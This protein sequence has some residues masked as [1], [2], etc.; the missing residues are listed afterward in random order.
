MKKIETESFYLSCNEM[1]SF[2]SLSLENNENLMCRHND[3]V[4]L[5]EI[6]VNDNTA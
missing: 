4:L 3:S 6:T 2:Y 5:L 1:K